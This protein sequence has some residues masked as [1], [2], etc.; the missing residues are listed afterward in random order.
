MWAINF[1]IPK[2]YIYIKF[3]G[4]KEITGLWYA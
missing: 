3:K 4:F 2:K 1:I